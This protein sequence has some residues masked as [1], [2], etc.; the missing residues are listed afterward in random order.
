MLSDRFTTMYRGMGLNREEAAKLLHVSERTV[1]NWESGHHEIPYSSYKLLRL[2]TYCELPGK[3]WDGWHIAVGQ[4]WSPEGFG[5]KPGDSAWWS[6][7]CRRAPLFHVLFK[8]NQTLRQANQAKLPGVTATQ[9]GTP[10]SE[11]AEGRTE[12]S[13]CRPRGSFT[14]SRTGVSPVTPHS[15]P[16]ERNFCTKSRQWTQE[17]C[18]ATV[19]WNLPKTL[20]ANPVK[21][22]GHA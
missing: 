3:A 20:V 16:V 15:S 13:K 6:A 21:G 18:P 14:T 1:R 10:K 12:H 2:L 11:T 8:E 7:L 5:F 19:R 4:L 22:G 17:T 9:P